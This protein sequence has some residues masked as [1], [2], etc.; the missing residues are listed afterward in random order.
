MINR[1]QCLLLL[2]SLW[3][4]GC[5]ESQ[6]KRPDVNDL[7]SQPRASANSMALEFATLSIVP[8]RHR[9]L[10]EMWN[11][12]DQQ[13]IDLD[14]RKLLVRNGIR[15][16][17][18]GQ[19]LPP[20]LR[21]LMKPRV[22]DRESLSDVQK[23]MLDK[24]VLEPQQVLSSHTR[25]TLKPDCSRDLPIV[26]Q[27]SEL[28]W[29]WLSDLGRQHH[30]FTDAASQLRVTMS[31]LNS[32]S[33]SI[34]LIPLI[35]HGHHRPQFNAVEDQLAF[36][37]DQA[38][39]LFPEARLSCHLRCGETL[40]L[41]PAQMQHVSPL[42]GNDMGTTFFQQAEPESAQTLVL[43]RLLNSNTTELFS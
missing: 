1:R 27:R 13:A 38:E 10:M 16:G 37:V 17:I 35:K 18:A 14:T 11:Q 40:L 20:T 39:Q 28:V 5:A 29:T 22:I 19:A 3:A 25:L 36:Q 41:G 43:L 42:D 30:R 7:L 4:G 34:G 24:G 23:E 33:V 31:P 9:L 6:K 21:S 26:D 32:T 12:V 8:Y 2:G 15:A